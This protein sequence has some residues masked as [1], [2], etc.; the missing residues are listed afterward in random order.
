[1]KFLKKK[2]FS[3]L[4]K[5][6]TEKYGGKVFYLYSYKSGDKTIIANTEVIPEIKEEI[7]R[8]SQ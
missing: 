5:S 2:I 8:L 7:K 3:L 4:H 6:F 1:M